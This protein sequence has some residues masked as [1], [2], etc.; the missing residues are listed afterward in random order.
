LDPNNRE[1]AISVGSLRVNNAD[2]DISK[3]EE[4]K[5][6]P[7]AMEEGLETEE[8]WHKVNAGRETIHCEARPTG[9]TLSG[10]S[11]KTN[12]AAIAYETLRE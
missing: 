11:Y 6:K 4:L 12:V 10:T 5:T 7:T 3:I 8:G 1:D 2:D 9:Q